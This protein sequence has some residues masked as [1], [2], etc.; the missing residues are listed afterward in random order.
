MNYLEF[1]MSEIKTG[2][3]AEWYNI[4][5][6]WDYPEDFIATKPTDW[7]SLTLWDNEDETSRTKS[8]ICR[9]YMNAIRNIIGDKECLRYHHINNLNMKNYQFEIWWLVNKFINHFGLKHVDK[10]FYFNIYDF[11]GWRK[12]E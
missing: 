4:F 10:N 3:L 6:W 8:K 12:Y 1:Q 2:K 9:P 5:N 7:D 11:M